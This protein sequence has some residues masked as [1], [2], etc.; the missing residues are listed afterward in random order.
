MKAR[1][2]LVVWMAL[3]MLVIASTVQAV[4]YACSVPTNQEV[5]FEIKTLDENVLEDLFGDDWEDIIDQKLG[6]R[7]K[8]KYTKIEKESDG[9]TIWY[10]HWDWIEQDEVFP[11][12]PDKAN[13]KL[14]VPVDPDDYDATSISYDSSK[15]VL[16]PVSDYLKNV[17]WPDEYGAKNSIVTI[18]Y[19]KG[20][21]GINKADMK[22]I[23]TY[24][25]GNGLR[26]NTRYVDD[27]DKIGLEMGA[28]TI[29]PGYELPILLGI[30]AISTIGMIYSIMK[31]R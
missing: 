28:Q 8:D 4:T 29:I 2:F 1:I 13:R 11:E 10:D 30:V 17:D 12:D 24:D 22:I 3:N 16:T 19:D 7:M 26:I 6:D 18:T 21:M 5:T 23:L 9:W 14:F 31:K 27:D 15:C 20:D 25:T